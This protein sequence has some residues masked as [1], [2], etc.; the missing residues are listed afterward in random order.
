LERGIEEIHS[1][2]RSQAFQ[3]EKNHRDA[4]NEG[5]VNHKEE[6]TAS[7]SMLLR[8]S[9]FFL[10][11]GA[12]GPSSTTYDTNKAQLESFNST[13]II[14]IIGLYLFGIL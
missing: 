9:A 3:V 1:V 8:L 6:S 2:Q 5:R 13:A 10:R 4:Q 12:A 7:S 11:F 14:V